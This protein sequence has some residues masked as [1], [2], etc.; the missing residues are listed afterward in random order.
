MPN[1]SPKRF[2]ETWQM[3]VD[4]EFLDAVE[5]LRRLRTPIPTK[6]ELVRELVIDP[7]KRAK[8][9]GKR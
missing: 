3:R 5:E 2:V 8:A 4:K 1:V 7:W 9:K 6:A